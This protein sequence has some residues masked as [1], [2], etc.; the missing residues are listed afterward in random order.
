MQAIH[1]NL[2]GKSGQNGLEVEDGQ[3]LFRSLIY[4]NYSLVPKL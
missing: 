1:F 3:I 4:E 2:A